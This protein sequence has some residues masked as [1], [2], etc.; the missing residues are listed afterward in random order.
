MK[1]CPWMITVAVRSRFSRRI[2]RSRAFLRAEVDKV[3]V[4]VFPALEFSVNRCH[5]LAIW[6][7]TD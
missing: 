6:D 5:L 3:G 2:G 7:R 1:A 4:Y